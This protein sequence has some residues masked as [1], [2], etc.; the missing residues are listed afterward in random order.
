MEEDQIL[1]DTRKSPEEKLRNID[2]CSD[3]F[4]VTQLALN[5]YGP[6]VACLQWISQTQPN[7]FPIPDNK[8]SSYVSCIA[9]AYESLN[10]SA[11]AIKNLQDIFK[12]IYDK[13][14]SF[15]SE[16]RVE[17]RVEKPILGGKDIFTRPPESR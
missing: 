9:F 17:Q 3:L 2:I 5:S 14:P 13:F 1:S 16:L 12:E 7:F 8:K 10:T 6:L 11:I 4:K 15:K